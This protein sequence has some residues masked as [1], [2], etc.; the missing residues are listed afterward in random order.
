MNVAMISGAVL[1]I[2][3]LLGA[4]RTSRD[5]V[6]HRAARI[7]LQFVVAL[8]LYFALFP[9][10]T[11]EHFAA[12]TLV[13]LTP[14]ATP[15]QAQKTSLGAVVVA[16]PGAVSRND[17]ERAPDLGTV[18]RRHPDST[19]LRIVG[20]GLPARDRDAVRGLVVDF[21][22]APLSNGIVDFAAPDSVR[23]GSEWRLR[24][25]VEGDAG[26]RVELRDPAGAVVAHASL[27]ENGEFTLTAQA[28]TPGNALFSLRALDPAGATVEDFSVPVTARE[29]DALRV[30]LLAG[31]PDPELKY[32]R[33]W[34]TDA[35]VQL[36]SRMTL[37]DGIAMQDGATTLTREALEE[38]DVVIVDERAW[39]ALD[40][41]AR[42]L[43]ID[44]VR[45]GLG[46]FM[47]VTGPV[48][49]AVASDWRQRIGFRV[50]AADVAQTVALEDA[51]VALA[52]RAIT[53]DGAGSAP[54]LKSAD[55]SAIALWRN[56][57][58]GRI[59]LWWLADSYRLGLGGDGARFGTL[60]SEALTTIARARGS[61]QPRLFEN[62]R[63]DERGVFCALSDG[64]AVEQA[65]GARIALSI[66]AT[67][68]AAYWPARSG[69]QTLLSGGGRWPF[70]VR[71]ADE[72]KAFAAADVTNSTRMLASRG[73]EAASG[74]AT[75]SAPLPR[76]PFFLG[77]LAAIAVLWW[78]ERSRAVDA[79]TR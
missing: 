33:R 21:D 15:D 41:G 12:G 56:E 78:F 69:W 59:A 49:D 11:D 76:W 68:C 3:A 51:N 64:A 55:G 4:W 32:L 72:G 13:V 63:I 58:Q 66:D 44:A 65:D 1:A 74:I 34:A 36:T 42:S 75:R 23:A 26:G 79:D 16:L 52:R 67:H 37:S 2:A 28:K 71:G 7:A 29:S 31:A 70:Y 22:A 43:L 24:G 53:V 46:L 39:N 62:M 5:R 14:G 17:V 30:T 20:G 40:Q 10:S 45:G 60:W 47:R 50:Q 8:L 61:E 19:R 35:N 54:L 48:P 27:A 25:R 73:D 57:G 18:L 6:R 38:T 9:P 77:W